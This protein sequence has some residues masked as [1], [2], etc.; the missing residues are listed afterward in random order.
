MSG[1]QFDD[2][3]IREQIGIICIPEEGLGNPGRPVPKFRR[4]NG[5][6]SL[7]VWAY[8]TPMEFVTRFAIFTVFAAVLIALVC[9]FVGGPSKFGLAAWGAIGFTVF[10]FTVLNGLGAFLLLSQWKKG[11]GFDPSEPIAIR[12]NGE[13]IVGGMTLARGEIHCVE[14]AYTRVARDTHEG[15]R[16]YRLGQLRLKLASPEMGDCLVIVTIRGCRRLTVRIARQLADCIGVPVECVESDDVL[17][18][19]TLL[20]YMDKVR[21]M[22]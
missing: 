13:I 14:V 9:V 12:S 6:S 15:R 11:V 20:P 8:L 1:P 4:M 10:L 16:T 7:V 17:K 5:E 19:E 3:L 22:T 18:E 21:L 2:M